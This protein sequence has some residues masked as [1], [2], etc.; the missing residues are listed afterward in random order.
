MSFRSTGARTLL[1]LTT[2][3]AAPKMTL[4]RREPPPAGYRAPADQPDTRDSGLD[5]GAQTATPPTMDAK[6]AAIS[7]SVQSTL[8]AISASGLRIDFSRMTWPNNGLSLNFS[9]SAAIPP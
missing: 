4:D 8:A 6:P 1:G 7:R 9:M 5:A 3:A 2:P